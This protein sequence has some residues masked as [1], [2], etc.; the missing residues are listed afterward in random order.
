MRRNSF[1][2][3][4]LNSEEEC[5]K[6]HMCER[7]KSSDFLYLFHSTVN[8]LPA[9]IKTLVFCAVKSLL[10]GNFSK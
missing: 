5:K 3:S 2:A 1:P 10:S 4:R 6:E 7:E 9:A 8:R